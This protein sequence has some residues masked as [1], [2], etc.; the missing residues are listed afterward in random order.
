MTS[1]T[2]PARPTHT[3]TARAEALRTHLARN[4]RPPTHLITA[5]GAIALEPPATP[6]RPPAV[7]RTARTPLDLGRGRAG[8]ALRQIEGRA[9]EMAVRAADGRV[10]WRV[11]SEVVRDDLLRAWVG[12]GF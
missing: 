4:V 1:K 2:L 5:R 7:H 10:T 9:I 12:R 11:A 3:G 6:T 8:V